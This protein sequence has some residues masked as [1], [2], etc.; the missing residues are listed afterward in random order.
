MEWRTKYNKKASKKEGFPHFF[1]AFYC[2]LDWILMWLRTDD[3]L[4]NESVRLSFLSAHK[5]VAIGIFFYLL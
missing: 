5:V 3:D 4:I 2:R 1:E